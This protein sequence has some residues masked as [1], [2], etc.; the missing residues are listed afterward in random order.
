MYFIGLDQALA[1]TGW[2][3]IS[4]VENNKSELIAYGTFKTNP[5]QSKVRRLDSLISFC[6]SLICKYSPCT[7]Y[8]EEVFTAGRLAHFWKDLVSVESCLRLF[9]YQNNL[10]YDIMS[11][12]L[13]ASNS[14]RSYLE[15]K[16]SD[17]KSTKELLESTKISEH[18]ADAICIALAGLIHTKRVSID[19]RE[20]LEEYING[21]KTKL[22]TS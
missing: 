21:V 4:L 13:K 11:P 10:E 22:R 2:A 20:Q 8:L 14:W 1:N 19:N 9:L 15:I 16:K 5:K 18:E 17:K 6:S 7:L 3:V 12:H